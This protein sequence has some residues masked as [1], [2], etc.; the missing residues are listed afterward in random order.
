MSCIKQ[1]TALLYELS[2]V[3]AFHVY[4]SYLPDWQPYL[5]YSTKGKCAQSFELEVDVLSSE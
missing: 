1:P 4:L 5:I 3:L 2:M